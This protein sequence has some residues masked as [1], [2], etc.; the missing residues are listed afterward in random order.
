MLG[1]SL[2]KFRAPVYDFSGRTARNGPA[3]FQL[4]SSQNLLKGFEYKIVEK[5]GQICSTVKFV[6]KN[7]IQ[8]TIK[9]R[10]MSPFQL[11]FF[12]ICAGHSS[13]S[14]L[15]WRKNHQQ[16]KTFSS[17][18]IWI[19]AIW[20]RNSERTKN[21]KLHWAYKNSDFALF[22]IQFPKTYLLNKIKLFLDHENQFLGPKQQNLKKPLWSGYP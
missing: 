17:L 4:V 1:H 5:S 11:S 3:G 18:N 16:I 2:A 20:N 15:G 9:N 22:S 7:W 6:E 21:C 19:L 10:V 12:A 8:V 14:G 13:I